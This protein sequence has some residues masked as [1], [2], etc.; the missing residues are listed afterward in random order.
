MSLAVV[1]ASAML[2]PVAVVHSSRRLFAFW[3]R[4][5]SRVILTLAGVRLTVQGRDHI[6]DGEPSFFVGNHPSALDIPI[7]FTALDGNIRFMA[8]KS[9]FRIPLFGYV[10]KRYGF[11]PI[12]REH[13]RAALLACEGMVE[14]LKRDPISFAVFPEGTRSPDGR[15]LPFRKGALRICLQS[16]LRV[17]PFSIDGSHRVYNRLRFRATPGPVTLTFGE[18]IA[19]EDVAAM[20][21]RELHDRVRR[22]VACQLGQPEAATDDPGDNG[23]DREKESTSG[24]AQSANHFPPTNEVDASAFHARQFNSGTRSGIAQ[25]R[26]ALATVGEPAA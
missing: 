17:V 4:L 7:L 23:T 11:I 13:P 2:I 5:W 21:A 20:S 1:A 25:D 10:L 24:E 19:V 26:S 22:A 15:L 18:P 8:K 9:L 14:Q 3:S 16:G 6:A 12:D